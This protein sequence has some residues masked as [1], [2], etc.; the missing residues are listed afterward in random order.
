VNIFGGITRGDEVARGL[1]DAR[2]Q[3]SRAVPM[4]VRIVGT[5]AAEAAT[6]LEEAR[7]VTAS[8]LD[9]AAAQAVAASKGAAA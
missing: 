9:D 5:N 6:L 1:I 4:V 2:K 8:S 7:F 3:Q